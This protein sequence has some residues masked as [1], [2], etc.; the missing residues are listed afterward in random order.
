MLPARDGLYINKDL[1][2]YGLFQSSS[3]PEKGQFEGRLQA[4]WLLGDGRRVK[5]GGSGQVFIDEWDTKSGA[6]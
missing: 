2:S 6:R 3:G 5:K 4:R 1:V